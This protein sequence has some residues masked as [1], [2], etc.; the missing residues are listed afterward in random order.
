VKGF[1][2]RHQRHSPAGADVF[3]YPC[4][5]ALAMAFGMEDVQ[6]VDILCGLV[7]CREENGGFSDVAEL[8]F[9]W[10]NR[11]PIIADDSADP[12]LVA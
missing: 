4:V 8:I 9:G 6:A 5:P 12:A 7:I 3:F 11:V 10:P 2:Q 1:F